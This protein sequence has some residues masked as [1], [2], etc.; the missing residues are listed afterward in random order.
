MGY[1]DVNIFQVIKVRR[2]ITRITADPIQKKLSDEKVYAKRKVG[3]PRLQWEGVARD[4]RTSRHKMRQ[5]TSVCYTNCTNL[6]F[7]KKKTS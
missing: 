2:H 1:K 3:A 4:T 6:K 5:N 7:E